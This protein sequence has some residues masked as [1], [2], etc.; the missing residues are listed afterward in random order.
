MLRDRLQTSLSTVWYQ[1]HR[2]T[3]LHND[4]PSFCRI[5]WSRNSRISHPRPELLLASSQPSLDGAWQQ[6]MIG[7]ICESQ[8]V[9][10]R[11]GRVHSPDKDLSFYVLL[12]VLEAF[13]LHGSRRSNYSKMEP[14]VEWLKY[15]STTTVLMVKSSGADVLKFIL[16]PC[17]QINEQERKGKE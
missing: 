17:W 12:I 14:T 13:F 16:Q 2:H 1:I 6:S 11:T 9:C 8:R 10:W 15:K 5:H 3:N 7:N 4:L